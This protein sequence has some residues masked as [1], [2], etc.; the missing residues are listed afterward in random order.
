MCVPQRTPNFHKSANRS[1]FRLMTLVLDNFLADVSKFFQDK[2]VPQSQKR[3]K[4]HVPQTGFSNP[5]P[6]AR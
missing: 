1:D 6:L 3:T 5:K 4:V 2:S